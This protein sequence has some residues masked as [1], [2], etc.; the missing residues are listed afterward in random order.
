VQVPV[1]AEVPGHGRELG[2]AVVL[3]EHK[4]PEELGGASPQP[5][6]EQL[7]AG[8][9]SPQPEIGGAVSQLQAPLDEPAEVARVGGEHADLW[10]GAGQP[11]LL[12]QEA[13]RVV[14]ADHAGRVDRGPDRGGPVR[15][16]E[17]PQG[18]PGRDRDLDDVIGFDQPLGQEGEGGEAADDVQLVLGEVDARRSPGGAGGGG[19]Q[20]HA[21]VPA[22]Q[23][24]PWS[25]S[26]SFVVTGIRVMSSYASLAGSMP[27]LSKTSG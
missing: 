27:A 19:P 22:N 24:F 12:T 15:D 6:G 2:Q 7:A 13:E 5:V 14:G 25:R 18:R 17:D 3:R 11:M 8:E 10:P 23:G 4:L 20:R 16:S 26:V 1:G 21:G 9:H